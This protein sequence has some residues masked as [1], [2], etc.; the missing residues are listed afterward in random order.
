[1]SGLIR[2]IPAGL[3]SAV[4]ALI[5]WQIVGS[6]GPLAGDSFATASEAV[7]ALFHLLG[8][9]VFWSAVFETLQMAIIGF[10][11]SMVI[12][13]PIGLLIGLSRF[14][15]RSTKFTFDFFKVIPPII[16]IPIAIL[17][18]GPSITMGVVL[19]VFANI[20]AVAIQTAYGV[21]DADP[22]LIETMRCYRMS[23]LEQIRFA[24]IPSAAVQISIATRI[25]ATASLIVAVVAGL[26][27]GAPGLGR[28]LSLYQSAG[29][30]DRTYAVVLSLGI[31]GLA[32]SRL[33]V[34]AQR[35][36]IFWSG[37]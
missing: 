35:R 37:R 7:I 4:V 24:R 9:P 22:V 10:V 21:R 31:L 20:F 17:V 13:V 29:T 26:V 32:T 25:A 36:A 18:I 16:L 2:R 30:A 3:V 28:L 8:D 27:G 19:I 12:A 15:Y 1:L 23:L 33:I 14:T 5:A 6:Y 34:R 11:L